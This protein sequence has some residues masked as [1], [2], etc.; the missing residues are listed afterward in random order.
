MPEENIRYV[1]DFNAGHSIITNNK[2]DVACAITAAPVINDCDFVQSQEILKHIYGDLKP[3]ATQLSGKIVKFNQKEFV[4][5]SFS[6]MS[7]DAYAYVPLSCET[8][9]CKVHVAFHGC[10]QGATT[11]GNLFYT[12]TGY[13]ELAD[14][15]DIIVLYPQVQ[16]SSG[17]FS[18]F[19]PKGC[20]DFWGYSSVN[21]FAPLFYSKRGPQMVAVKQML[22]RLAKPRK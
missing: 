20:W 3:P 22:D 11:I 6:S 15:N 5:S 13:N 14:T 4:H 7:D 2:K 16:P 17:F 21:Q 10:E 19:N 1:S 18:P 12:T 8:V 9:T